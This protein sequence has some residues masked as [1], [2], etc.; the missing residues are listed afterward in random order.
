MSSQRIRVLK[1]GSSVLASRGDVSRAL[2]EIYGELREG[3]RVVAVVSAL[4]QTTERLLAN[5]RKFGKRPDPAALALLLSTGETQSV[6]LLALALERAGISCS[7]LDPAQLGLRSLGDLLDAEP[8]RFDEAILRAALAEKS[9]VVVPGFVGRDECGRT[10]LFGRGGSDLSALFLAQRLGASCRLVKDVAGVF[11]RDPAL[12]GAAARRFGVLAWEDALSVGGGIVQ[13][14]ALRFAREQHFEFEVGAL[15][16]AESTLVG[17]GPSRFVATRAEPRKLRVALL[18]LGTV[19]LGVYRELARFP[20]R[21]EVT[22]VLV[23]RSGLGRPPRIPAELITT[24][25][26]RTRDC[27]VLVEVLGGLEPAGKLIEAALLR[28]VDVV[29]ANKGLIVGRGAEYRSL[30]QANG[31]RFLYSASVC[32]ALP[33]LETVRGLARERRIVSIE[34]ILNSTTNVVLD[35]LA[36]GRSFAEALD[37]AR[38]QG[39]CESDP[40]EDLDGTDAAHKLVLVAREAFGE[41]LDVLWTKRKGITGI[42]PAEVRAASLAGHVVR[43]VATCRRTEAGLE[44]QLSPATLPDDHPLAR[45]SAEQ[46]A[47][48]IHTEDG[49]RVVLRGKGA[50][51][52]P[53]T[54]AVLGDLLELSRLRAAESATK[55]HAAAVAVAI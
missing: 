25:A 31:A 43:L 26:E 9:V 4:G 40:S 3:N 39:F 13:E 29:S 12:N 23:R 14:K 24:D 52:W 32:G 34:G 36:A 18:G 7:V 48:L 15:G 50:G 44:L 55:T 19:G 38:R 8:T 17:R 35:L 30:A 41:T 22:S 20:E 28:G 5:A 37:H 53:T 6:A 21:F 16:S 2:H 51:R 42:R 54:Q 47:V 10:T 46:N 49:A 11:D 27:D 1:F 33:L 45:T